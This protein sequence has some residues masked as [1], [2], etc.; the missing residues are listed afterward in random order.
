MMKHCRT[1]WFSVCL[2]CICFLLSGAPCSLADAKPHADV[3]LKNEIGE[4]ITPTRNRTDP[5]SP[6]RTCGGCHGYGIITS[7]YHFQQ[8]FDQMSDRYSSRS[9]W[10]LSPG[11]FGKWQPAAAAALLARKS[12]THARQIDLSTYDWIGGGKIDPKG[13]IISPACGWCH[14]G[15]GPLE[16][17]RGT[18]GR[19]DLSRNHVESERLNKTPFDGDYSSRFTPDGRSRF[20]ESGVVEADCLICHMPGYRMEGRNQQLSARNYRWAATAGAGFGTISG[21]VF[22]YGDPEAG[23]DH[24]QFLDGTWNLSRRPSV[25]YAWNNSRYFTKDGRMRGDLITKSVGSANCQQCHAGAD[26]KNTGSIH[27]AR[28]DAHAAA[29]FRCTDCHGLVGGNA[30][31]RLRHQIAKGWSPH[32]TVRD[33]LDGVGIKTCVTCHVEGG[34]S[35]ARKGMPGAARNPQAVHAEKFSDA[36]FHTFIIECTGCHAVSQFAK[37]MYLLDMSVGSETG[38]TAD[39]LEMVLRPDDYATLAAEPWKPWLVRAR[40]GKDRQERYAPYVPKVFQWFG[41]RTANGEIRP[42]ALPE[43]NQAVRSIGGVMTISVNRTDGRRV[44]QPSVVSEGDI[45]RMIGALEGRGYRNVVY[46]SDRVYAVDKGQLVS[47]DRPAMAHEKPYTIEHNIAPVVKRTAYGHQGNPGGCVNCHA[48]D[49][50]F[51]TKLRIT[52]I[53]GFLKNDYPGVRE[54]NARPQMTDWGMSLVPAFD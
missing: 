31:E 12:N 40:T 38:Y 39:K 7:G 23:P 13:K 53:R 37:G 21:A 24:A 16:Y 36:T 33:D 1:G 17:G 54:P 26:A 5:Y 52:N 4:T 14:P 15:G 50:S 11:M 34:Y 22:T 44:K 32:N 20:R 30:A 10:I 29:G 2:I 6:R 43:V 46:V 51:F 35:A 41:E 47:S 3:P 9:P 45:P 42:I 27:D 19:R 28:F 18:D 25:N 8:G 48:E 49:A